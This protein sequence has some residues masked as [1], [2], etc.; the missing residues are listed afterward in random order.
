MELVGARLN[1]MEKKA[2]DFGELE[3]DYF[4]AMQQAI[5][6]QARA[7]DAATALIRAYRRGESRA[8]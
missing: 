1:G 3:Q 4:D 2:N 5:T 8:A 6:A 7:I